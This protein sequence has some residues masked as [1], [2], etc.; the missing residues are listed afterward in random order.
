MQSC[1]HTSKRFKIESCVFLLY[2]IRVI[3]NSVMYSLRIGVNVGSIQTPHACTVREMC[4]SRLL[5]ED[6]D[7]GWCR[8]VSSKEIMTFFSFISVDDR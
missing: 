8:V 3:S 6:V 5:N 7:D 1:F 2:V 4:A